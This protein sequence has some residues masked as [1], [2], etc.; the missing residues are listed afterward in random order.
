MRLK[1]DS[2]VR[3]GLFLLDIICL[4]PTAPSFLRVFF[5]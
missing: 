5:S 4:Q 2:A 1:P 3:F